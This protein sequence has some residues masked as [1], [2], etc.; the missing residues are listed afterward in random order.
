MSR[1]RSRDRAHE[2][3][4]QIENRDRLHALRRAQRHG[5]QG[6]SAV[7]DDQL[8]DLLSFLDGRGQA[9]G[10][11]SLGLDRGYRALFEHADA[12]SLHAQL[13]S[14]GVHAVKFAKP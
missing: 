5:Q 11:P 3:A 12:V 2:T 7:S 9:F 13:S 14:G 8:T 10:Y 4:E 1:S 6:F